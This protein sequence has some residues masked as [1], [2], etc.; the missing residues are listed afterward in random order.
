MEILGFVE[1]ISVFKPLSFFNQIWIEFQIDLNP[2][3][4]KLI[5]IFCSTSLFFSSLWITLDL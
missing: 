1:S 2:I 4:C 5:Y 3:L